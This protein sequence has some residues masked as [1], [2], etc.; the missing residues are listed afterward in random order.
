MDEL[1]ILPEDNELVAYL[2]RDGEELPLPFEEDIFLLGIKIAGPTYNA[3]IMELFEALREGDRVRLVREPDNPYDPYAIRIDVIQ[4]EDKKA[5]AGEGKL[6]VDGGV[7]LGYF[8]QKYNRPFARLMDAGKYLYGVV[9]RKELIGEYPEIV[10]KIYMKDDVLLGAD[11][12]GAPGKKETAGVIPSSEEV[13]KKELAKELVQGLQKAA[14]SKSAEGEGA[15]DPSEERQKAGKRVTMDAEELKK[16][17][18]V[19][20]ELAEKL[21]P[22]LPREIREDILPS[23]SL[24][25]AV[26]RELSE[27]VI[28]VSLA[29]GKGIPAR[30]LRDFIHTDLTSEEIVDIAASFS[31]KR[32]EEYLSTVPKCFKIWAEIDRQVLYDKSNPRTEAATGYFNAMKLIANALFDEMSPMDEQI[33]ADMVSRLLA[34]FNQVEMEIVAEY[35]KFRIFFRSKL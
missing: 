35:S 15:N 22:M 33:E 21:E 11:R 26:K 3:N 2:H 10:V 30:T 12:S 31:Q 1:M 7:K 19:V 5:D 4:G 27:F 17:V 34:F 18:R 8:P 9:R 16:M 6:A 14:A 20:L 28:Y 25:S 23:R 13:R 24:L 29:C 32:F